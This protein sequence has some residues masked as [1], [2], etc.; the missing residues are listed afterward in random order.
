M[1]TLRELIQDL[2]LL[3]A[4]LAQARLALN[5]A[6]VVVDRAKERVDDMES[7]TLAEVANELDEKNKPRYTNKES[8]EA[9]VRKLLGQ[10]PDYERAV[11]HL[12]QTEVD[13]Q[14]RGIAVGMLEDT[15]KSLH[16]QLEAAL[17]EIRGE[18]IRELTKCLLEFAR[19]EGLRLAQKETTHA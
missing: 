8:R 11:K 19:L 13:K 16:C 17:A 2:D 7:D 10:D 4:K 1:R 9:A 6:K 12:A 15:E 3:P 5:D 14:N 18:T